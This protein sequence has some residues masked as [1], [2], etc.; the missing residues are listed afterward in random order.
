[1]RLSSLVITTVLLC[2][3][4]LFAQHSAGG[5]NSGGG[6]S[7][8]GA[9][10][11]GSS[12]V[13]HGPSSASSHSSGGVPSSS[14]HGGSSAVSSVHFSS[15]RTSSVGAGFDRGG[16][17][18]KGTGLN[19][20]PG[21]LRG[22]VTEKVEEKPEKKGIF[23]F[24]HHKKPEPLPERSKSIAPR[25]HCRPGQ[26]CFVRT[27]CQ[28]KL[29]WY[30]SYCSGFYDQYY[31][32]S[33]CQSLAVQLARQREQMRTTNDAGASLRYQMLEDQYRQCMMRNGTTQFSSYLFL[34]DL[35]Y[36]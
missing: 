29:A 15:A 5:G 28:T 16:K 36:P 26:P 12:S 11:G 21:L 24:L 8:G 27:G 17:D 30:N 1:M 20:R 19:I 34:S 10:A 31:W 23:S 25:P 33:A 13:S 14:G 22:P 35:E 18:A 3:V 7:G 4:A 32:F 9:W 6:H 2:S